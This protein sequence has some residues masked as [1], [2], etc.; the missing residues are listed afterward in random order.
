MSAQ[1]AEDED[2]QLRYEIVA[3]IN[4]AKESARW[5]AREMYRYG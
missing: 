1:V 4:V 3:G 2:Y 5:A